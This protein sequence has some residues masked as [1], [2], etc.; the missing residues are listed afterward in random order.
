M[1]TQLFTTDL[2][3]LNFSQPVPPK[4]DPPNPK[5]P[6][7]PGDPPKPGAPPKPIDPPVPTPRSSSAS[8]NL[9]R[10]TTRQYGSGCEVHI[11]TQAYS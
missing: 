6:P 10:R 2:S 8:E 11:Q 3:S 7:K 9:S 5:R 4:G 1:H